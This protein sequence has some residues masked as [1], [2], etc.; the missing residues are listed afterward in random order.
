MDILKWLEDWYAARCN[1]DWEHG[2]GVNIGTL[3]NPGWTISINL[4]ETEWED[5]I[6]DSELNEKSDTDW[7]YYKI[8]NSVFLAGGD[9]TKL[10]FLLE[11][12]RDIVEGKL[13]K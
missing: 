10:A 5:L 8:E 12:F 9:L 3:D 13:G 2:S 11:R 7:Y 4:E 1:G 6:V